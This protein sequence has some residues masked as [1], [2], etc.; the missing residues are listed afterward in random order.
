MVTR[1]GAGG[2][3]FEQAAEHLLPPD[4]GEVGPA[5][6]GHGGERLVWAPDPRGH[7]DMEVG[8]PGEKIPK[9]LGSD[10][11]AGLTVGSAGALAQPGAQGCVGGVGKFAP[12]VRVC[13]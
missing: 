13:A 1:S 10:D 9:S 3:G 5:A 2:P 11:Q 8:M 7:E 6:G 4:F 12:A